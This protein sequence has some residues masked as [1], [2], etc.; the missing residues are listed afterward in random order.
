MF[1]PTIDVLE[2]RLTFTCAQCGEQ[3]KPK[4]QMTSDAPTVCAK[5]RC[6]HCGIVLSNAVCRCGAKHGLP[7][8][9][10]GLC[11]RCYA[12]LDLASQNESSGLLADLL[13]AADDA[14][15]EELEHEEI[16][17]SSEDEIEQDIEVAEFLED[18]AGEEIHTM[19]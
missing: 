1:G 14:V 17:I 10:H 6:R 8:P 15:V 12:L 18:L 19:R 2:P 4:T 7:S 5:C 3:V 9:V 16:E 13:F 11:E